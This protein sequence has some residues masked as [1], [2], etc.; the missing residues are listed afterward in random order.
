LSSF[1]TNTFV[2]TNSEGYYPTFKGVKVHYVPEVAIASEDDSLFT[3]LDSGQSV[4]VLHEGVPLFISSP[5]GN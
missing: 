1:A 2:V 3:V 4:D 5:P